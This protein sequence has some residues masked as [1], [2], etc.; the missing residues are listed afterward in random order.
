L[1]SQPNYQEWSN[2]INLNNRNLTRCDRSCNPINFYY[3]FRS[4]YNPADFDFVFGTDGTADATANGL[5][6]T[7]NP[8]TSTIPLGNE[9]AKWLRYYKST[10]PL[11]D[12]HEVVFETEMSA[13]QFI[14][15][16]LIPE[17]MIPRIRNVNDDIRLA[18]AA[19]NLLDPETWLVFDFILSNTAIYAVYE[20][21]P[22]GKPLFNGG[23]LTPLGDYA[24]FTNAIWVARRSGNNPLEDFS[25]LAIG[26][27]K[28]KGI[29]TWYIDD[30]P[31]FSINTIGYRAHDEYRLLDHGGIEQKVDIKSLRVGFGTLSLLDM[32]LP[33]NYSRDYVIDIP[34]VGT[35]AT[36]DIAA[37]ALV[38][39]DNT[40]TYRELYPNPITGEE[41]LLVDPSV[42]FAYVLGETP[43]DNRSI[44]LFGQGAALN[45]RYIRVYSRSD[46]ESLEVSS[47]N[48]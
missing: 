48:H 26:I 11:C 34:P 16:D 27:H 6:I 14:P 40:N 3:D 15:A 37:S 44:K 21:L 39:I 1:T 8:F 36:R 33:N 7:S 30:T 4:A 5:Q 19:F 25:K 2:Y 31:V 12:N 41:R 22:F 35:P 23:V 17:N 42:T 18:S 20:R 32:A 10:F 9:H 28:G 38:Q 13:Q 46:E 45:I 47:V 43:D 24:A 29:V